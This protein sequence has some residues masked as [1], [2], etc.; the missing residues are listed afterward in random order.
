MKCGQRSGICRLDMKWC[1]NPEPIRTLCIHSSNPIW[2]IKFEY[3]PVF[4]TS[5]LEDSLDKVVSWRYP[6]VIFFCFG[7]HKR[8][9]CIDSWAFASFIYLCRATVYSAT[10]ILLPLLKAAKFWHRWVGCWGPGAAEHTQ[11]NGKTK[12]WT[13]EKRKAKKKGAMERIASTASSNF[14]PYTWGDGLLYKKKLHTASKSAKARHT[15]PEDG[16]FKIW[17]RNT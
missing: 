1:L 10:C 14:F 16:P 3:S 12:I 11:K 9:L 13:F 2:P 17:I 7:E 4:E 6:S 8:E 5:N 15:P